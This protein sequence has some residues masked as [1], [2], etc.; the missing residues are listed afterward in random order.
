MS[1]EEEVKLL[2]IAIAV[3]QREQLARD[4]NNDQDAIECFIYEAWQAGDDAELHP[5][6]WKGV[7]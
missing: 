5:N 3:H 2:R 6:K 4:F 7:L 1:P